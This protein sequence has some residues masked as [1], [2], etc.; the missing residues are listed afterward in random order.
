MTGREA[1]EKYLATRAT[2]TNEQVASAYDLD[3]ENI[4][5]AA[6]RM[7][8]TGELVIDHLEKN[9]VV[10][11]SARAKP[12]PWKNPVFDECRNSGAMQ[13]LLFVYGRREGIRL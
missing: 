11:R 6:R 7:V 5:S 4:G 12:E 8:R 2:F 10:Y 9:V 1:I 3:R 13:R